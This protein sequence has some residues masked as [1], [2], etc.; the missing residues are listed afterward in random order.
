[1]VG[2][3]VEDGIREMLY[4]EYI[5]DVTE[6]TIGSYPVVGDIRAFSDVLSSFN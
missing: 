1:M 6:S 2:D 3:K 5:T 4:F